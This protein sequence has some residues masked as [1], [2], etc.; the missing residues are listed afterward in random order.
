MN[1][2]NTE[3]ASSNLTVGQLNAVVKKLGGHEGAL[4][5]LRGETLVVKRE[6]LWHVKDDIIYF[7][8]TSDGTT[9]EGWIKRL[10][11]KGFRVTDRAE[12]VLRSPEFKSTSG[13]TTEVAVMKGHLLGGEH[14]TT[15]KI[16]VTAA[17]RGFVPLCDEVACLI[18][19]AYSDDE[20]H[21][22]DLFYIVPIYEPIKNFIGI[23]GYVLGASCV[24][25]D[26]TLNAF[27][28]D[29]KF[30]WHGGTGFAFGAPSV[31]SRH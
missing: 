12:S 14:L 10:R 24:G 19:D 16:R 3:F 18:R 26:S 23:S 7:S 4:Q 13:V 11:D 30:L 20:I 9:G 31:G 17:E 8:V 15:D 1:K 29:P 2:S 28:H 5:F 27:F 22:M 6:R 21:A 25:D